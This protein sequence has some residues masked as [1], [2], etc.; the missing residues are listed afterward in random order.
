MSENAAKEKLKD[1]WKKGT[2]TYTKYNL[3]QALGQ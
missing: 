2:T 3:L 1:L